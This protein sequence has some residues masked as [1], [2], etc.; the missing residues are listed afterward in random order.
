MSRS[1]SDPGPPARWEVLSEQAGGD[2]GVFRVVRQQRRHQGDGRE[3]TFS[4]IQPRDWV[5]ALAVT[6]ARE[7][8]FVR[9]FRFGAD[10]LTWEMPAGCREAGEEPLAAAVRELREETGYVGAAPRL[11]GWNFPNPALQTNQ[12]WYVLVPDVRL[13]AAVAPDEHE[14]LEVRVVPVTEAY[15]W[16]REGRLTHALALAGLYFLQSVYPETVFQD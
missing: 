12:C 3:G 4:L 6:P 1:G 11:L 14:D 9:Q 15:R 10:Q 16:G 8:I 5:V 2:Y 13:A 7:L